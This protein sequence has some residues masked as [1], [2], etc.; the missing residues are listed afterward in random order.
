MK[1]EKPNKQE[2]TDLQIVSAIIS[3]ALV[4]IGLYA[5]FS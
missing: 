3:L 2:Y 1:D 4:G 5:L